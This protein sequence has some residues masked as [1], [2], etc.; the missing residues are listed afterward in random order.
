MYS[1][2]KL[3]DDMEDIGA[4]L[5]RVAIGGPAGIPM[6]SMASRS[7]TCEVIAMQHVRQE[8]L[9][10]VEQAALQNTEFDCCCTQ[11]LLITFLC[12]S[13]IQSKS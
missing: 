7:L 5:N 6:S 13:H 3:F 2:V 10:P 8:L 11:C 4:M 1:R 9:G 12:K